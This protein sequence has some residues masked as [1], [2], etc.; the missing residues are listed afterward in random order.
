MLTLVRDELM[1]VKQHAKCVVFLQNVS[2][3]FFYHC[4]WTARPSEFYGLVNVPDSHPF[5]SSTRLSG[6]YFHLV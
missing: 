2:Q 5:E 3:I 4:K 1:C 6:S